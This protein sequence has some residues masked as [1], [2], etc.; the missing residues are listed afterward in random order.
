MD[1]IYRK[2]IDANVSDGGYGKCAE[3]TEAMAATFPELR[4]VRG[5]Y[6]CVAWGERAHWWMVAP[7]DSIVD[8]TAAQF[9]TKGNGVYV[10]LDPDAKAPVG[11]CPNCGEQFYD[12][13]GGGTCCSIRC[14]DAYARYCLNPD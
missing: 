11:M 14:A 13:E 5:H 4:R 12:Y 1:A 8:P 6:Y 2:W 9:S 7:D 10:E 3:V